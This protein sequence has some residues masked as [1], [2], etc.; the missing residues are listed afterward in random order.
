MRT[1]LPIAAAIVWLDALDAGDTAETPM[2]IEGVRRVLELAI[3]KAVRQ[4]VKEKTP[5]T[6]VELEA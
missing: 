3:L 2:L 4:S 1:V 6:E 5:L